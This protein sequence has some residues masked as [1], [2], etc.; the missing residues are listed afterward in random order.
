[1][2]ERSGTSAV[3]EELLRR[4]RFEVYEH[5]D[6]IDYEPGWVGLG[7]ILAFDGALHLRS[8][9]M[10]FAAPDE[11][12]HDVLDETFRG[13]RVDL[14]AAILVELVFGIFRGVRDLPRQLSP[15]GSPGEASELADALS[16]ALME[17]GLAEEIP[18]EPTDPALLRR[19]RASGAER[20]EQRLLEVD[21]TLGDWMRA[22]SEFSRG[23]RT[24]RKAKKK[25]KG[26]G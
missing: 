24:R 8:P 21:D 12:L 11:G 20:I 1:M 4:R 16:D 15:A 19:M 2:R 18:A 14:P 10:F 26:R 3:Y 22:L 5:S 17:R 13:A 25:G 7:R 9:G 23:R 6:E